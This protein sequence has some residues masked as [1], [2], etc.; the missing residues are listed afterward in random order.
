MR[1]THATLGVLALSVCHSITGINSAAAETK[2]IWGHF[3]PPQSYTARLGYVP[4]M[5]RVEKAS[6]GRIKFQMYFGGAISRSPR[7]QY[8]LLINGMQD[9]TSILP[10]YTA[11]LFPDF[12][13][14]ALPYLFN[15]AAES[16]VA[17]WRLYKK[18]MLGGL[19]KVFTVAIFTNGNSALH[20]SRKIKSA[21]G[22]KGL[23]IRVAGPEESEMVK[24]LGGAP[25]GMSITQV[26]ESLN[27][28]VIQ[29]TMN[30]WSALKPFR[31]TPLIKT[32]YEEPLGTRSFV[33]MLSMKAF[34]KL[35]KQ[36]Q[37]VIRDNSGEKES[38]RMGQLGDDEAAAARKAAIADPAR[39]VISY[40][41]AQL[42]Q[43]AKMFRH[44][45]DA[46]IKNHKDGARKYEAMQKIL[47]DIRAGS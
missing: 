43:R 29:G 16:S 37:Q 38:K 14:F 17:G 35:P 2:L 20:F 19:E 9:A 4:W 26:A 33:L 13:M 31:I 8:E 32:H 40:T 45:R 22:I 6:H 41:P 42:E 21:E 15:S 47:S 36:D 7:K 10:S 24:I 28:G 5:K 3:V 39:T 1:Y 25:V 46:W 44:F 12:T 18:G 34:N 27:R 30:G 23:K 11:A